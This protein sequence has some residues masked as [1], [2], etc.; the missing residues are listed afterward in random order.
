M[1]ENNEDMHYDTEK[2]FRHLCVAHST[3]GELDL[4]KFNIQPISRFY[5]DTPEN[6]RQNQLKVT[7]SEVSE[8]KYVLTFELHA[9]ICGTHASKDLLPSKTR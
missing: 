2:I 1:G 7:D 9:M 3:S 6:A 8:D 4:I 5:L